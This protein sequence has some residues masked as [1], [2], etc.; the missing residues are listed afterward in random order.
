MSIL[1]RNL[2]LPTEVP[3]RFLRKRLHGK[4][5]VRAFAAALA[6]VRLPPFPTPVGVVDTRI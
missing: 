3:R 4:E 2:P 5:R 1:K 6:E